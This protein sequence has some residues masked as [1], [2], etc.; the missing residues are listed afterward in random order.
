MYVKSLSS[1]LLFPLSLLLATLPNVHTLAQQA[2]A[3]KGVDTLLV[4][5]PDLMAAAR[6]WVEFRTE[7]GHQIAIVSGRATKLQIKQEI[8]RL[9]RTAGLKS[10]VVMG[11]APVANQ[12]TALHVETHHVDSKVIRKWGAEPSFP[13][14]N[15]YADV[16]DDGL[17]ELTIGRISADSPEALD[18][19][20]AKIIAYERSSNFNTW[21]RRV[22]FVAG[23]G[24]FGVLAD[25]ILETTAK[26][27][28]T[29]GIPAEYRTSMT[30][31]SWRSPYSPDPRLF[32]A[33]TI[34]RMNE[35]CLAWIYLGHGQKRGLDYYRVPDGG[36]PIFSTREVPQVASRAGSPIAVFLSCYTGAFD[37][38]PDCLAEELLESTGGPVA[39]I[40]GTNVTMP[41]AMTVMGNAM[42]RELFNVRRATIG[43]VMLHAKRELGKPTEG[44]P[45]GLVDQL[46]KVISPDPDLLDEERAEHVQ[47]FQLIGDPLLRI[48]H[49]RKVAVETPEYATAGQTIEIVGNSEVDGPCVIELVCRRDRMTF[50]PE[51]RANFEPTDAWLRNLQATYGRAN[52]TAWTRHSG[53]IRDGRL[54]AELSIP[55]NATGPCHVRIYVKGEGEFAMGSSD[56]YLR[57]PLVGQSDEPD[58]TIAD[59][60]K[61]TVPDAADQPVADADDQP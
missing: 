21:R 1:L 35:G 38:E 4:C 45:R 30:Q 17:P 28:I 24:G 61:R 53:L 19:I 3:S 42:L 11:D 60:D 27:F 22:N 20:I 14:D 51:R 32:Q 59:T 57:P 2:T 15:Y 25:S 33:Q 39:V 7:Q 41:Y 10:V 54:A 47:L 23:V 36:L 16:D 12:K 43:E 29:D 58:P 48:H 55:E 52:D 37:I 49:P 13:T 34:E 18:G 9:A 26:K 6:P 46:A 8:V 44:Q 5:A 56:V 31:A 40:A 50:R